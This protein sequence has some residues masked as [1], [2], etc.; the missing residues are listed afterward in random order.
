MQDHRTVYADEQLSNTHTTFL[1]IYPSSPPPQ[2]PLGSSCK[3]GSM[4]WADPRVPQ[5]GPTY[6]CLKYSFSSPTRREH[7]AQ[8]STHSTEEHKACNATALPRPASHRTRGRSAAAAAGRPASGYRARRA[9][10]ARRGR[11][12]P[13]MKARLAPTVRHLANKQTRCRWLQIGGCVMRWGSRRRTWP[14]PAGCW[15]PSPVRM[16][17]AAADGPVVVVASLV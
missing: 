8:T 9:R 7:N 10:K 2:S 13:G 4:G 14:A 17:S 16:C 6:C 1:T 15:D 3:Y 12:V 11:T 5:R